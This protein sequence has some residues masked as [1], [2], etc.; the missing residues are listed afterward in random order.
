M[1][2]SSSSSSRSREGDDDNE[3]EVDEKKNKK[4]AKT[5]D[6]NELKFIADGENKGNTTSSSG[7]EKKKKKRPSKKRCKLEHI[8]VRSFLSL[9]CVRIVN[10]RGACAACVFGH[11][12]QIVNNCA[13]RFQFL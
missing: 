8:L 4:T 12:L 9:R 1:T 3:E 11:R 10:A 13:A 2:T 6:V 5:R 7:F